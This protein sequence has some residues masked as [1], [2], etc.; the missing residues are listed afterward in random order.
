MDL[1]QKLDIL[2]PAARFDACDSFS[3]GGR[4]YTPKKAVWND[5]GTA[6]E[7]GPDGRARPVFRLLMSSKCE[8]NCA[9]C[10]LR[11]G[12]DTPRAALSPEELAK[13]FLPRYERGGVQGLFLSTGVEGDAAA[14][15]GRMLDGLE[16]LRAHH[17][18]AGYVHLKLLPGTAHAEVERAARLADRLS[19]NIEAPSAERLRRIS[20]ERDWAGDLIARLVW[21]RDLQRAGL[22]K[23]GLATQFVVGAAG[24]SDRELLLTTSWLYRELDM[25]RVYF[26]A[27]RPAVGTP[28]ADQPPTPFVREQRL[29]EADWLMRSYGFATDELPY[30][31][32]GDLPLHID[33]KLAWALA[34]PERFPVELNTAD[35]DELLRVP[36]LGPVSIKRIL[37]LR[38]L[39][40]FRDPSQLKGLGGAAA[41][42]QDFVTLDGRYFGRDPLARAR[43]YAPRGPLAEQLTLW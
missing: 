2:S 20:P 6:A 21:A 7:S 8:W 9:Y 35:Q 36:G 29:K 27:F 42:A 22:V 18:Y 28:L 3:Q 23:G 31:A 37:R 24:E 25:R 10:P 5:A 30:D 11:A 1:D 19:L 26:G 17:G 40:R 33:P 16:H 43:H 32:G 4:R 15:T 14:A 41:R 12:N 34:H 38:R 13:A 39:N